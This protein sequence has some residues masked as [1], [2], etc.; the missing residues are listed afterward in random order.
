M[1]DETRI[2]LPHGGEAPLKTV[3]DITE[4]RGYS[5]ILS[6][7]GHRIVSVTGDVDSSITTPNDV[8]DTLEKS[9]LPE[10]RSRYP[11]L[12]YS[13]EGESREQGED[14]ASLGRNMLIAAMLIY[15]LLG[16]Q[17]RSYLQP[18]IIMVAIPFGMVGAV[19]G[20][21][22]LGYDLTF[23][24]MFGVVALTGVVVNDSV[25]LVDYLNH[26]RKSGKPLLDSA[27]IAVK[28]RFRPILL[29]T[30]ST[31][32]GLLPM[33][34][35]TSMQAQFLIPMVVSLSMGLLFATIVILFLVPALI[36]VSEDIKL[37][38]Y[39]V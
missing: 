11:G 12:Q 20:H 19:L 22:F 26:Q 17:L 34:L 32:L 33:L 21:F 5:E 8:I 35:E 24:S 13:F 10:L 15:V 4:Q 25:V 38:I 37:K 30:L 14:L 3:V 23:I 7:N 31:C 9:V 28:R 1:L 18:F 36:L 6:V 2:R 39:N 16:A 29:T 27:V